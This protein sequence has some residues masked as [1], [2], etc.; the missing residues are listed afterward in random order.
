MRPYFT[1][2]ALLISFLNLAQDNLRQVYVNNEKEFIEAL[3]DNT[4]IIIEADTLNL[5]LDYLEE[6]MGPKPYVNYFDPA[7]Q[8]F[9][10]DPGLTLHGFEN[11]KISSRERIHLINKSRGENVFVLENCN[12]IRLKNLYF[13][14]DVDGQRA[15]EIL[16]LLHSKNI[17]MEDVTFY[18]NGEIDLE[19]VG[20]ENIY[21]TNVNF[22][23]NNHL[24]ALKAHNSRNIH[25][26]SCNFEDNNLVTLIYANFSDIQLNTCSF[27]NNIFDSLFEGEE[28]NSLYNPI[29]IDCQF[30]GEGPPEFD[31]IEAYYYLCEESYETEYDLENEEEQ[32]CNAVLKYALQE[33]QVYR[34]FSFFNENPSNVDYLISYF[35]R[36]NLDFLDHKNTTQEAVFDFFYNRDFYK[37][38]YEIEDISI[39][40]A[41]DTRIKVVFTQKTIEHK[42]YDCLISNQFHW[43][44]EFNEQDKIIAVTEAS[45]PKLV[46]VVDM[47]IPKSPTLKAKDFIYFFDGLET[48]N[49]ASFYFDVVDLE[50][51]YYGFANYLLT[52]VRYHFIHQTSTEAYTQNQ[53]TTEE[54]KE[55]KNYLFNLK[56][57]IW[58]HFRKGLLAG[59]PDTVSKHNNE[60]LQ[61]FEVLWKLSIIYYEDDIDLTPLTDSKLIPPKQ[62]V[63]ENGEVDLDS[64]H[65]VN[66]D[67]IRHVSY[68]LNTSETYDNYFNSLIN[69][70]DQMLHDWISPLFQNKLQNTDKQ[71]MDLFL[72]EYAEFIEHFDALLKTYFNEL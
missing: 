68:E 70:Y 8:V 69:K 36:S 39:V 22:I 63:N 62:H 25:L 44:L 58:K 64:W 66:E 29:F 61:C 21:L 34:M 30:D 14:H 2:L 51:D 24:N 10:D 42:D 52:S 28:S 65:Q 9:I 26:T 56:T 3:D 40:S 55:I 18:G 13:N 5:T 33:Y 23:N 7:K 31:S 43:T 37:S 46:E 11:L 71:K 6:I 35:E 19:I 53:L 17:T 1:L 47:A 45:S 15:T 59:F 49:I 60:L 20:T 54:R 50:E 16:V 4:H 32:D 48:W 57:F 67:I 12:N 72:K 27:K 38:R 41:D